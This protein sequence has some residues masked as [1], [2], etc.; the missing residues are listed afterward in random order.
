MKKSVACIWQPKYCTQ[1]VLVNT[2]YVKPEKCYLFFCGDR[3]YQD[4]YSY[5]GAKVWNECR[6]V[7]NGKIPCFE[8]PLTWLKNEGTLPDELIE[9]REQQY[10]KFKN[11]KTKLNDQ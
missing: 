3:N 11:Y 1:M 5:D 10:L 8:I 7:S 6:T 9:I 4:L 2:M